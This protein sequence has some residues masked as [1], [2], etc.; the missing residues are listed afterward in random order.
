MS[1]I[2]PMIILGPPG[3]EAQQEPH[4]KVV[5]GLHPQEYVDAMAS[6]AVEID[7]DIT[8]ETYDPNDDTEFERYADA[9]STREHEEH[10]SGQGYLSQWGPRSPEE[11]TRAI[12]PHAIKQELTPVV[13]RYKGN[14]L[15]DF[16][17]RQR[18]ILAQKENE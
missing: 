15:D 11:I 18:E 10:N 14:S 8:I 5:T 12:Q 3:P 16:W 6:A 1:E 17:A 7:R 13:V 2:D 9:V 4:E